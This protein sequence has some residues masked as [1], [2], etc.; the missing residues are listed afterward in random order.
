MLT[1]RNYK[2]LKLTIDVWLPHQYM[3]IAVGICFLL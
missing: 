2:N 1:K 3:F